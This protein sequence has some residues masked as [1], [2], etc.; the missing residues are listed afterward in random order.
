MPPVKLPREVTRQFLH[1]R[2]KATGRVTGE[3]LVRFAEEHGLHSVTF[4]RRVLRLLTHDP[5]FCGV[6]HRGKCSPSLRLEVLARV[7]ATL[8]VPITL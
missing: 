4:R 8:I 1:E 3:D 6:N 5:D 2:Q 7:L